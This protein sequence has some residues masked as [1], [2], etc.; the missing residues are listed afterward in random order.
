MTADVLAA[1][2]DIGIP[3]LIGVRKD[4][5]E[6]GT[7][8]IEARCADDVRPQMAGCLFCATAVRNGGRTFKFR[9]TDW[10]GKHTWVAVRR[11][12]YLCKNCGTS[13]YTPVPGCLDSH[14]MTERFRRLI[15]KMACSG[16]FRE[17]ARWF[18]VSEGTVRNLF[19]EYV[20]DRLGQ[21]AFPMPEVLGIDEKAIYDEPLFVAAD[22]KRINRPLCPLAYRVRS[23]HS[24]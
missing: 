17:A 20:D 13:A 1:P 15:L 24:P 14:K 7:L 9:D 6:D 23:S 3:G 10:F 12:Q 18:S 8:V 22:P 16:T 21:Y 4:P 19:E 2:F 11:Q 5:Q